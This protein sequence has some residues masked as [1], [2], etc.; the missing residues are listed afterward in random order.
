[1]VIRLIVV[2]HISQ[3]KEN[4]A[5]FKCLGRSGSQ[6]GRCYTRYFDR[7]SLEW[8]GRTPLCSLLCEIYTQT[9][10]YV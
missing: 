10:A 9:L 1:M 3:E 2:I 4:L 8:D 5:A 6:A 7:V